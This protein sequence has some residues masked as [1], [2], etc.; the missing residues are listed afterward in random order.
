MIMNIPILLVEDSNT[1]SGLGWN[2]I[3]EITGGDFIL[4]GIF[5]FIALAIGML[6]FKVKSGGAIIIGVGFSYLLSVFAPELAFIFWL[7]ALAGMYVLVQ[8]FRQK[9]TQ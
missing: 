9:S 2:F 8:G 4:I 1:V 7:A 6:F 3:V 5:V